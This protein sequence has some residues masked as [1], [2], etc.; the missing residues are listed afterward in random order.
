MCIT[1]IFIISKE[2]L[3]AKQK[4]LNESVKERG[5]ELSLYEFCVGNKGNFYVV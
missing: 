1:G 4:Q 5:N 3:C 2:I